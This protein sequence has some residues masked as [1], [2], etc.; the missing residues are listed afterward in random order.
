M[1]LYDWNTMP[2]EQLNAR[3][4]RKAIHMSGLTIAL[5][6]VVTVYATA[7]FSRWLVSGS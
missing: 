5:G 7:F 3:I 6:F 4:T 1:P 2:E